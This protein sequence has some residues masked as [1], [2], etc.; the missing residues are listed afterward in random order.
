MAYQ[1]TYWAQVSS[2]R[3]GEL[4]KQVCRDREQ[5]GECTCTQDAGISL[6]PVEVMW[7]G[8]YPPPVEPNS[9]RASLLNINY[10]LIIH[11]VRF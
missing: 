3:N 9:I 10:F 4:L 2:K 5:D 11:D 1:V 6:C 8:M 7:T